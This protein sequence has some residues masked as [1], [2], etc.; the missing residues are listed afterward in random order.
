MLAMNDII[1]RIAIGMPGFL[2]AIVCHEWAHAYMAYRFGDSTAKSQGRLSL[3]PT[4]HADPFGTLVFPLI[5]AVLGG[6]MF[7][8]A[9][10][11]PV[12][13]RNFKNVRSG[14]FWVSFAGPLMNLILGTISALFLAILVS[15]V[16]SGF[17]FYEPFREML[18]SSVYINFILAFF[19]LIP[20][21]P[22]D[23]SKM[24]SSFL[25][26]E[27][28]R[29]YEDL[30]RYS[31]VFFLVLILTPILRYILAP[32]FIIAEVLIKGFFHLLT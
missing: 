14:I 12:N 15:K 21:P 8:W 26:Y 28:M 17:F 1:L 20:F 18:R 10:P 3:N 6:F 5:G 32:A 27:Q 31:F 2:L 11:V 9:R 22:L 16:S 4:V 29:K 7:G 25:N 19:N 24:V 23:G 13:A 30:A